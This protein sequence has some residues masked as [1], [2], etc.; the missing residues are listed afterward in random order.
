MLRS[1]HGLFGH[2]ISA[3]DGEIGKVHNFLFDDQLW[4]VRYLVAET[5]GWL[6]SRRVLIS[7]LAFGQPDWEQ[8]LLPVSLSKDQVR[9]S[10]D[11]DTD[12]PVSRQQEI[13][14]N[15]YYG[16]PYYWTVEPFPV[17][18]GFTAPSIDPTP[19][20]QPLG[21]PHLRSVREVI[22]YH[23]LASDGEIGHVRDFIVEDRTWAVSYMV[24][25]T[26]DWLPGKEVLVTPQRIDAVS[27]EQRQVVV[28][29]SRDRIQR[30]PGYDPSAPVNRGYEI[31]LYDYYGRPHKEP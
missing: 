23:I 1:A 20:E 24:V 17:S 6:S 2:T 31:R 16:W 13:L 30:S 21:D 4:I 26:G 10:P 12:K 5:G 22:G 3:R 19:P 11:V 7:P 15:R 29:L 28:A 25:D 9:D 18:V 14:M 27:W 8:R